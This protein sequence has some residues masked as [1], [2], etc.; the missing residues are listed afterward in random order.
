TFL[1]RMIDMMQWLRSGRIADVEAT[2]DEV[3]AYGVEAGEVDATPWMAGQL[4][5]VRWLQGRQHEVLDGARVLADSPDLTRF[6]RVYPAVWAAFAA[7]AGEYDEARVAL[8]RV[9]S[10]GAAPHGLAPSS[11]W[12]VTM[13]AVVEAIRHLDDP[14]LASQAYTALEPFAELPI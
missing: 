10:F 8:A 13:F 7:S 5:A 3:H 9:D 12:L 4:L 1:A 6:N 2:L 11:S 14:E